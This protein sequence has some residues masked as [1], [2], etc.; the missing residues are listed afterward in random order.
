VYGSV[1]ASAL[2]VLSACTSESALPPGDPGVVPSARTSDPGD[3][4][5]ATEVGADSDGQDLTADAIV[6]DVGAPGTPFDRRLLGTNVGAWLGDRFE[7][8]QFGDALRAAGA[9]HIRMPGGSWSNSYDWLACEMDDASG[10]NWTWAARP[11][12]YAALL[13]STGLPGMWTVSINETAQH[14]AALVAF[15]NGE[16]DDDT[17]IGVD[18]DG[19]DWGTV[20]RWASLRADHGTPAPVG[21]QMWEIGNEVYAA[22]R[23]AGGDECSEF[24][25]ED[26]W[27]CE[28]TDYIVGDSEHDGYL[29]IRD[30]MRRVDPEILVGGVG[31]PVPTDWGD[32][33]TEVVEAAGSEL[34]F[35]VV[36]RY[37]FNSSEDV[38]T[39]VG[40]PLRYWP[41]TLEA[42][43]ALVGPTVPIAVTEHN[44]VS[45]ATFDTEQT[46]THGSNAIFL[47]ETIGQLARGGVAIANQWD[48]AS[49]EAETGTNYGL[50]H[51]DTF[52]PFPV[53]FAFALWGRFGSTMLPVRLPSGTASLSVYAGRRDDGA[54]TLIV[55]NRSVEAATVPIELSAASPARAVVD[56]LTAVD[57]ET[58]DVTFNGTPG[59]SVDVLTTP[60]TS[61]VPDGGRVTPT[62]PPWSVS[63]VEI[64]P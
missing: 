23:S 13:G 44:L 25:W 45:A 35:Y 56:T 59:T 63:L 19:V 15:F 5:P 4:V 7:Q 14:S 38:F 11:S 10:C 47:A 37:G 2:V 50:V 31:V 30:A 43:T 42:L 49:G 58:S 28:G 62:F 22:E 33:G 64:V 26:V 6:V 54:V 34:D 3:S 46:I 17:V 41:T 27:T 32:F 61:L 39:I 16:V 51:A 55:V 18:R 52:R 53:F 29:A 57:P 40:D 9:T 48:F 12:D 60:G 24:G 1:V 20:G 21:I 36:H 8:P